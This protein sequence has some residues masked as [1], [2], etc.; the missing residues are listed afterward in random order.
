MPN[1]ESTMFRCPHFG[2][3]SVDFFEGY[4]QSAQGIGFVIE[5]EYCQVHYEKCARY[6]VAQLL[7]SRAS[8]GNLFPTERERAEAMIAERSLSEHRVEAVV[9]K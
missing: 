1:K 7:G 5:H 8:L 6:Q 4:L 3:C 9:L 2:E